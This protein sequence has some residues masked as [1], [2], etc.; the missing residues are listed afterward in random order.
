MNKP[1]YKK[2]CNNR[3]KGAQ[4]KLEKRIEISMTFEPEIK[5]CEMTESNANIRKAKRIE[6]M[7]KI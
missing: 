6:D 2:S 1:A 3:K 4:R 7:K 5:W